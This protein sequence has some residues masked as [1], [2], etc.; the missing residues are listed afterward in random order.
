MP[1]S[2]YQVN[3]IFK[4]NIFNNPLQSTRWR[5]LSAISK[6]NWQR[7]NN[8]IKLKIVGSTS[9]HLPFD[10]LSINF[11]RF[12]LFNS[13]WRV[14]FLFHVLFILQ[15]RRDF[16]F[17]F[18]F[19]RFCLSTFLINFTIK[20]ITCDSDITM[21]LELSNTELVFIEY[22]M[23]DIQKINPNISIHFMFMRFHRH[24]LHHFWWFFWRMKK[25]VW[26][27]SYFI[28]NIY[29]VFVGF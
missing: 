29:K 27:L 7:K 17:K 24:Y 13:F 8:K 23:I 15:L 12:Y 11:L 18:S 3:I 21:Q 4:K 5:V 28:E 25:R 16:N 14:F 9:V 20:L 10:W 19:F 1:A 22:L 26:L 2:I 6:K